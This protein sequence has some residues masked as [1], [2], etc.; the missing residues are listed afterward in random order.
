[1]P[2]SVLSDSAAD[3]QRG[4]Q[5]IWRREEVRRTPLS[6]NS[7]VLFHSIQ[8][9]FLKLM[10]CNSPDHPV[11]ECQW[12]KWCYQRAVIL[13][14][15]HSIPSAPTVGPVCIELVGKMCKSRRNAEEKR[16]KCFLILI[17]SIIIYNCILWSFHLHLFNVIG[18]FSFVIDWNMLSW[19]VSMKSKIYQKC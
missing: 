1:M 8:Y 11:D 4:L 6:P 9:S 16:G 19:N 7:F 18:T 2:R 12:T 15:Y 5:C 10:M 14:Q 13:L 3:I 17:L